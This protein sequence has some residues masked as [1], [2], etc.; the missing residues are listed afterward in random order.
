[1]LNKLYSTMVSGSVFG[2][3]L[4][5][6]PIT[7]LS[8]LIYA[9]FR[10][11][12]IKKRRAPVKWGAEIMRWFFVCYITG[13]V[14]LI[15]VPSN[16]WTYIWAN[17]FVGYSHNE[18]TFFSG[19]FNFVP[20]L[21]KWL[22]GDLTVGRWVLEMLVYNFFMFVPFGF[23]LPFV[24]EKV[25]KRNIWKIAVIVPTA[26]EVMQPVVGRSFDIDDIIFNF[27]GII[28]GYLIAIFVKALL[29]KSAV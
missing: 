8:G 29:K 23:F 10:F 12:F 24:S 4:Q 16:L 28:A 25:S 17:I 3:F 2:L 5:V 21:F 19:E 20:A 15:L 7:C 26:V 6:V 22:S 13:L 1:M 27:I 18:I 11:V 9:V 14:N